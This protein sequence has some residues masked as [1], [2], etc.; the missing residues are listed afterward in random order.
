MYPSLSKVDWGCFLNESAL[1]CY[2][3]LIS[4]F[5]SLLIIWVLIWKINAMFIF[6]FSYFAR[7]FIE[8]IPEKRLTSQ[9]M[10]CIHNMVKSKLFEDQGKFP[11]SPWGNCL[12]SFE[13]DLAQD[14]RISIHAIQVSLS[15]KQK[16]KK[17]KQP[18][19]SLTLRS[20]QHAAT[21]LHHV[22]LKTLLPRHRL[23]CL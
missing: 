1:G 22:G 17:E 21:I 8:K 4:R 20:N 9:K 10:D 5:S 13:V 2:I 15:L 11:L 18:G 16:K 7:E 14:R 6:W 12:M 19:R 3:P 23:L